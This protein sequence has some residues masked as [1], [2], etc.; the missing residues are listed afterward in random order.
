MAQQKHGQEHLRGSSCRV[1]R[2]PVPMQA[3]HGVVKFFY[4]STN[5]SLL[6]A[7]TVVYG[8]KLL[9]QHHALQILDLLV[10][11]NKISLSRCSKRQM[12]LHR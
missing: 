3:Q 7:D 11:S 12:T 4:H 1:S 9:L 5:G 2:Q 10:V 8:L 6:G